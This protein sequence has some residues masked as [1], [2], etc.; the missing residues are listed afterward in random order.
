MQ[1]DD[2][3]FDFEDEGPCIDEQLFM[4]MDGDEIYVGALVEDDTGASWMIRP[5]SILEG[6]CE[7][8]V[9]L[10][11]V[12]RF[13]IDPLLEV[14]VVANADEMRVM[15]GASALSLGYINGIPFVCNSMRH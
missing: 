5:Y 1:D 12:P 3:H 4:V 7:E 10:F 8:D 11:E 13:R 15:H 9:E 2:F 6:E 14:I